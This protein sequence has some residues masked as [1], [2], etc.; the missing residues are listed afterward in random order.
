MGANH[1]LKEEP[2][3]IQAN[4]WAQRMEVPNKGTTACEDQRRDT[5]EVSQLLLLELCEFR[6]VTHPLWAAQDCCAKG[7][8]FPQALSLTHC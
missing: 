5:D 1:Q 7:L 8:S 6:I 2:W 3:Q 4:C